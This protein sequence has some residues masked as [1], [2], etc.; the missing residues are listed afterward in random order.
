MQS[1]QNV[2]DRLKQRIGDAKRAGFRVRMEYLDDQQASW[3]VIGGV[4]TIFIDLSQS[5]A[6]QLCQLDES[7]ASF[8][9]DRRAA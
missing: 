6:E 2:V 3:C 8:R 7:L 1:Q 9:P 4:K 5:A